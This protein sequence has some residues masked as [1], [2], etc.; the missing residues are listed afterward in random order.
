MAVT[1]TLGK[2][3]TVSG[4]AGASELTVTREGERIDVSTRDNA[5]PFK[6]TVAGFASTT[7]EGSV[8]ATATTSFTV[9][10]TYTITLNGDA[11]ADVVCMSASREEPQSG[12]ITYR[13]KFRPGTPLDTASRVTIGPG[14]FRT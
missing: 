9:G 4:L 11:F 5:K 6:L 12:V 10:G 2:N 7:I 13:L 1:Y 8:F 3:Y 14:E